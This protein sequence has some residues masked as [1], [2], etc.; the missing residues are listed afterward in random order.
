M[1]NRRE[2][3]DALF[4]K[5]VDLGVKEWMP[6]AFAADSVFDHVSPSSEDVARA[7]ALYEKAIA[8]NPDAAHAY[9]GLGMTYVDG[10]GDPKA[11]IAALEKAMMLDPRNLDA[12]A[13]LALL[14]LRTG[15]RADAVKLIDGP[16]ADS[17]D[18]RLRV[19]DALLLVDANAAIEQIRAGH[20]AEGT[21]VLTKI[22][23]EI[24]DPS[25]KAQIDDLLASVH[26]M[27]RRQDQ[28]Q[29]LNRAVSFAV[30]RKFDEALAIVDRLLPEVKDEEMLAKLHELRKQLLAARNKR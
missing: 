20:V 18:H 25:V 19:R 22:A 14:Y 3:A 10:D 28:A 23:T 17:A 21:E 15:R 7:R 9:A 29:E 5:A 1:E 26:G 2:E 8:L 30:S 4:I 24:H 6:Y 16:L 27:T 11:G 13:N 12:A